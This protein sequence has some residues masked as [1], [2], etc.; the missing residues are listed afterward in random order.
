MTVPG[1]GDTALGKHRGATRPRHGRSVEFAQIGQEQLQPVRVVPE[2]V[3][4][5]QYLGYIGC[6][7]RLHT[8]R[9]QQLRG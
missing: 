8:G 9:L 3:T 1:G 6:D 2:Q 5:D 4:F 7:R